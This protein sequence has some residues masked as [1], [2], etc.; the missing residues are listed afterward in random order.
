MS[1]E[2]FPYHIGEYP[3]FAINQTELASAEKNPVIENNVFN[4]SLK[5]KK[6]FNSSVL[7]DNVKIIT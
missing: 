5:K 2:Q 6:T 4:L 7:L 1:F 3:Q